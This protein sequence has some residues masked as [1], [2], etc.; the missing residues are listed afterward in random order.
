VLA[1]AYAA[2]CAV[3]D[4]PSRLQLELPE[5]VTSYLA[6]DTVRQLQLHP[7]I[8]HRYLWSARGPWALHL[9]QVDVSRC[10]L[11]FSVLQAEAR[12]T[13]GQ[14]HE[15]VSSMVGRSEDRILVAV[16]A[17]FFTVEGTTVGLEVVDGRVVSAQPR[18][19]FAW[20]PGGEP[21]IGVAGVTSDSMRLGWSV[22]LA[23]GDGVTEALGG[24]PDLIDR[25][26]RVGDLEV[27]A[28]PSFAEARHP[29]TGVGYDSE[30]G[31]LWIVV[32]DGRQLPY[33]AGMTLPELAALFG[34]LGTD[35]ALNLD[36]GGSSVMVVGGTPVN[37]PSDTAGERPVVNALALVRRPWG[38]AV[39]S[40]R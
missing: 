17:D 34:A 24:F 16:N 19:T 36:G 31:Q 27:S 23:S 2:A 13:G 32:V 15:R 4:A 38:C 11:G 30:D 22:D 39:T 26:A 6:P 18:P 37:R 33:S 14:G 5:E 7:G 8:V 25:G 10:D 20:R 9:I 1:A 21:W 28:R 3:P 35:E 12:E 40:P 29:R